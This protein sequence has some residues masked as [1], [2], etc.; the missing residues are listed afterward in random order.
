MK[1][2]PVYKR[3]LR[4]LMRRM[5]NLGY[6]FSGLLFPMIY[7][8]A[9]GWGLGE[10]VNVAGGYIGFLAKGMMA[11]SVMMNSFQQTVISISAARFYYGTFQ[12][13]KLSPIGEKS[14]A[15]GLAMAGV[16]RGVFAGVIIALAAWLFFDIATLTIPGIIGLVLT[17][18]C[19]ASFGVAVG[20][21]IKG[22]EQ[23]SII[24]NFFITPMTFFCGSF[25]PITNLPDMVQMAVK[26]LPL[27]L[28]NSLLRLTSWDGSAVI[29]V[30]ILLLTAIAG[31]AWSVW[32]LNNY[33][34]FE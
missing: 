34:E 31:F 24:V 20:M 17:A 13:L 26:Y 28:A 8:L 10:S 9:F 25:F 30:A 22:Q 2:I 12:T 21:S 3:E 7:L 14:L 4:M 23:F 5:G 32:R 29:S 18:M 6:L 11:I 19:F 15:F 16:T 1:W 33:S 27:S